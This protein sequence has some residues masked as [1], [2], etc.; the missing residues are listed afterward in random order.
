[1]LSRL[2]ESLKCLECGENFDFFSDEFL[3]CSKG[4]SFPIKNG[5]AFFLPEKP[6]EVYGSM[7]LKLKL[8]LKKYPKI[9]FFFYNTLGVFT[10]KKGKEAIK[11]IPKGKLIIDVGSGIKTLRGDV[12]KVDAAPFVGVHIV[13]DAA[14]L[15]FKNNSCD[16]V[17]C[18][19]SLEHFKKPE[20]AVME[21]RRILKP[22]GLVYVSIPFIVGF[23]ASPYDYYRWTEEGVKE[24]M[25][26]F[27]QE[28]IGVG[29]G[30]TYAM[31][32]ILR[33]WLAIV[34][35]FNIELL[36]QFL[37]IAF[38]MIFA[39]LNFLDYIFSRFKMAKNIAYGFYFIGVKSEK[40]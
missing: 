37:S 1:M 19:S 22:G 18:E 36:Y 39:P 7:T 33:E 6:E 40:L 15:P 34:L 25:N 3:K 31:T 2:K 23:H 16:A 29:W 17:V 14:R 10:G 30:P 9:F 21:F 24:L 4:H 20:D 12:I 35:S 32:T 11:N 5:T 38:M 8:F 27:A 26:G 28:E 13:A